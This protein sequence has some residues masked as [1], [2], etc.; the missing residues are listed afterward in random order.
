MRINLTT[1]KAAE[2]AQF[3]CG[4]VAFVFGAFALILIL[5][6]LARVF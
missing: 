3:W 1:E 4:Y 2:L 6:A 5:D